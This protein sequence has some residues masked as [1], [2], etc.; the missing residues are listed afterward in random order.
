M[1]VLAAE[2]S[3]Y[4][5]TGRQ[6]LMVIIAGTKEETASEA[7]RLMATRMAYEKGWNGHGLRRSE[8]PIVKGC[9]YTR[10]FVFHNRL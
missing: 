8:P 4:P 5:K 7:A 2:V 1:D 3:L 9:F 6:R 10:D